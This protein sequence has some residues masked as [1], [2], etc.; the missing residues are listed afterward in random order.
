MS[1]VAAAGAPPTP[2]Q[3]AAM[4]RA[5]IGFFALV[6][7]NF[8]AILDIQIV[9]SSLNELQAGMSASAAEIAWVQTSYLIAEVIAIPLS[10]YLSRMMSTR[11]YFVIS[12]VGFAFA[13]LMCA[14]AWSLPSLLV[15]RTIQG[16]LG[17]GMIPT[18]MAALF[19]LFPP[20][21]RM[22][23]IVLVSMASTLAPAVGPSLGGFLTNTFS[24]H[25]MFLVNLPPALLIS[26]VVWS[27]L[28]RIDKPEWKLWHIIDWPGLFSMALFLGCLEFALDEGPR[29]DWFAE[30]SVLLAVMVGVLS[31]IFFF[32]R[33]F[34]SLNPIVNL[35]VFADRNFAVGSVISFV[36]GVSLYGMVYLVP[37]FL[38]QVRHFNSL[39]IGETMMVMGVA[40][41]ITAPLIGML[42]AKM[43][44][45]LLVGMGL[46]T[47]AFGVWLNSHMTSLA[48]PEDLFWPQ[49]FRGV[50]LMCAM[51]VMSQ[52]ALSTLPLTEMKNGSALFNL[53]RNVGGAIGLACINT[54]MEWRY[55]FHWQHLA[56]LTDPARM[57]VQEMLA[58][59][60]ALP[61]VS[62]DS[63]GQVAIAMLQ[64]RVSLQ[65]TTLAFNDIT[66]L[67]SGLIL[68]V[69]LLL[70]L[71]Q[72]V[73]A[74]AAA[75]G[76]H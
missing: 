30:R 48:G 15:F 33:S 16:F 69:L 21:K 32:W 8:M 63:G 66:M 67:L 75:G 62:G 72:K 37:L 73:Q 20:E 42:S 28:D 1:P 53:T 58:A 17:G 50:G 22:G 40:M 55:A 43:D 38:G 13:S 41:F 51:I 9:A 54:I 44:T 5:W 10:G 35:R 4:R 52:L 70:P 27:Y 23:P 6:F 71:I 64:Q 59:S 14:M 12:A 60:A 25:W 45:R 61:G 68:S 56:A 29:H 7:G 49:I 65:A 3:R 18:T 11:L 76:G 47:A 46:V 34:T 31:G 39:Q 74:P 24:W 57:P 19:M 36:V 26:S 2:E